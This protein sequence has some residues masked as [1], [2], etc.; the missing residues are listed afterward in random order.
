MNYIYLD[1]VGSFLDVDNDMVYPANLDD[2]P[3]YRCGVELDELGSEWIESLSEKDK[4]QL[5]YFKKTLD[6]DIKIPYVISVIRDN[7]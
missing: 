5:K 4:S 6:I 7:N 1:S 2:T 3:D